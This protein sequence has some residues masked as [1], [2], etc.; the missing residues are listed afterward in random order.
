MTAYNAPEWSDLFVAS[1]GASAAL[2]GA[3]FVVVSINIERIL[4]FPGL[5]ER[6]LQTPLLLLSVLLVSIIG[7][8]PGQGQVA[9]GAEL[10][11]VGLAFATA[12]QVLLK[13]GQPE[14]GERLSWYIPHQAVVL[15]GTLPLVIGGASLMADAGGGL[16]WIAAGIIFA[17]TGAVANAWV[18]LVEIL[19]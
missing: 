16:Y 2:T 10:L 14:G 12:L 17:I 7:L 5:P 1:A 3:V 6:A 19:R 9:L 15:T 13:R 18:L 8:I 11:V 4:K